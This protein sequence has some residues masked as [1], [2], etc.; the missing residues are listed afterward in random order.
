MTESE[1][2]PGSIDVGILQKIYLVAFGPLNMIILKVSWLKHVDH[3]CRTIKKDAAGFWTCRFDARGGEARRNSFVLPANV[4]QVFFVEDT[5]DPEWRVVVFHEPRSKRV[6]GGDAHER[7]E[8]DR[9]EMDFETPCPAT[10]EDTHME[11]GEPLP[12]PL[13]QVRSIDAQIHMLDD[14][15]IFEDTQYEEDPDVEL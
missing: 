4:S 11:R 12:V 6:T 13:E 10:T 3:G 2:V 14:D 15:A 1:C 8:A 7:F 5:R 9:D